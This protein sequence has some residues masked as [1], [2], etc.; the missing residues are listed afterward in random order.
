ME[1]ALLIGLSR[2]MAL[3]HQM[4]VVANNMAN[5][6][7]PGYKGETLKFEEFVM[8]VAE[9]QD[10]GKPEESVSYVLDAKV[11]RNF[12]EGQLTSTGNKL[13]VA[14]TGSGWFAIQTPAGE[15]YTR[16]GHFTLN[17]EGTLVTAEGH[18]VLGDGGPI[19]FAPEETDFAIAND[20][21]ISSSAGEKGKLKIVSF[22]DL[23]QL[24]KEGGNL[25]SS[26]APGQTMENPRVA[27]GYVENSNV[28]AVS[29][30]ARMI[31]VTRSYISTARSIERLAD[32]KKQAV[33]DLA[34]LRA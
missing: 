16:D 14:V 10:M 17:N 13:D 6:N 8:P 25:F 22:D 3:S 33:N 18:Q 27:Q 28:V 11:I 24:Q 31:E 15:R 9:F 30:M 5:L 7:T 34:D 2:Q 12:V 29:E 26:T 32:L 23:R 20:G 1:N 4:D 21:S 19:T